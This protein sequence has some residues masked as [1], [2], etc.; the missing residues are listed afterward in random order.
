MASFQGKFNS[1]GTMLSLFSRRL[2][3]SRFGKPLLP[4]APPSRAFASSLSFDE[5]TLHPVSVWQNWDKDNHID[6]TKRWTL[7]ISLAKMIPE[8]YGRQRLDAIYRERAQD[9]VW[10]K[11]L[12]SLPRI[13]STWEAETVSKVL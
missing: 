5:T 3:P 1:L 7:A 11:V 10:S 2:H 8:V 13:E 9:D 6:E 12:R 4:S